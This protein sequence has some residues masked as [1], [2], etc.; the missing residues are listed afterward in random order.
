MEGGLVITNAVA[1]IPSVPPLRSASASVTISGSKIH[2]DPAILQ[3]DTGGTLRA[4]GDFDL[5]AQNLSVEINA[6]Q[7]SVAA[8]KQ[9]TNAWFGAP[10]ALSLMSDGKISGSFG[11]NFPKGGPVWSGQGQFNNVSM[12]VP[13]VAPPVHGLQGKFTLDEDTFDLPHLSGQ[14]GDSSFTGSY[15]Y[16]VSANHPEHLRLQLETADL[17]T[18]EAEL[19]PTISD[20]GLLSR[21]P[22]TRRSIPA[23][24]ASRSMEG[25]V[26]IA[27]CSVNQV[28]IGPFSTHFVW[29]GTSVQLAE[30]KL[31]LPSGKLQGSGTIALS[32]RLPRYRLA[33]K[34]D[35]YPWSGG[36][37]KLAGNIDTSGMGLVALQH[38]EASGDF[39]G[40]GVTFSSG[41]PLNSISGRFT[42]AF[43]GSTPLLKL[44]KVQARQGDEDWTGEGGSNADGKLMLDLANGERQVHMAADLTP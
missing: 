8:F 10:H 18:L 39:W 5:A 21:L 15:R 7:F 44:T 11:V 28:P 23:W 30:L 13:G 2:I 37:L 34:V 6:D 43:N 36:L 38:L 1:N 31:K 9:T 42:F 25:E 33:M 22:F 17:A 14:L 19:T 3:S 32:A 35:G 24:L 16:A 26:D 40:E 4:G 29:Q 41:D 20:Q 27:K 12:E